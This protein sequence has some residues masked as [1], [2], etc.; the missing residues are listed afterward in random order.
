MILNENHTMKTKTKIVLLILLLLSLTFSCK[1]ETS[2]PAKDITG[3]WKWIFTYKIYPLSDS[4]PLTPQNTGIQEIL[5]FNTNHTWFKT[6]N[7]I[8]VDS[9]T[10]SLGHGSH[11]AYPGALTAIYDSISYY[12]NGIHVNGW[13]DYYNI[14]HDTLEFSPGF[15][16]RY[17]SYTLPF[18]GSKFWIKQ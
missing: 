7:N 12:Q 14:F 17:L 15:G 13:Q 9:G 1:K 5:V 8:R 3:Q 2:S 16:D 11:T 10:F 4:N 6:Q 18:N